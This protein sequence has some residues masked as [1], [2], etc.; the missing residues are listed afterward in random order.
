[1]IKKSQKSIDYLMEDV[2]E[3]SKLLMGEIKNGHETSIKIEKLSA[4]LSMMS[5]G[6]KETSSKI[7]RIFS[8]FNRVVLLNFRS[9]H[10]KIVLYLMEK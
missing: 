3:I 8:R 7:T 6:A 2:N 4:S 1:M 9:I 5:K 10:W